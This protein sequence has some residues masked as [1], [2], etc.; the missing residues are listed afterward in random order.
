[1]LGERNGILL[2][3]LFTIIF[4]ICPLIDNKFEKYLGVLLLVELNTFLI[5]LKRW[6]VKGSLGGQL[7][8]GLF[9]LTWVSFRLIMFPVMIVVFTKDYYAYSSIHGTHYNMVVIGPLMMTA[10]TALG[11]KWTADLFLKKVPHKNL[12]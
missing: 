3:H 10:L 5:V 11:I 8:G 2:H 4:C 9:Y 12:S 7:C 1:M 6:L